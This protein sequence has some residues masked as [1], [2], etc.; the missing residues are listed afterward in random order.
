MRVGLTALA[1]AVLGCF[2]AVAQQY[3]SALAGALTD[4]TTA[5]LFASQE[6]LTL[7]IDAPLETIFHERGQKSTEY[8]GVLSYENPRGESVDIPV[9]LRTRGKTRLQASVCEFPPLRLDFSTNDV[10]GTIFASQD[11]L[12][13]VTHC[14]DNR[15]EH[16]QYVLQEYLIYRSYNV[17]TDVSFKVRL[18]RVTYIDTD[19]E[20]DTLTRYAFLIEDEEQ[21]AARNGWGVVRVP[22]IPPDAIDPLQLSLLE[23]FQYM[24]GNTDWSAFMKE[25]DRLECCHNTKP[26][27]DAATGPVF[28]VP[29]DFDITGVV[30]T[31]YANRLFRENLDRMGLRSVRERLY[32]GR[33]ASQPY[34]EHTFRVFNEKRDEIYGL[35]RD[36]EGL[37]ADILE[38]S[39]EYLDEF[40]EIINDPVKVR[41]EISRNCRRI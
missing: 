36:Q 15:S 26:I 12:K 37:E 19:R 30:S 14:Q 41:R 9:D 34:L 17:L 31:R 7:T 20:R 22:R 39:L 29:Y 10:D 11:K 16:E 33:C 25:Q 40:Y 8:A 6:L 3:G 1:T 5:A 35:Y 4:S 13:L 2:P 38:K 27:G 32:K 21:L 24:I 28:P 23:I 18:A